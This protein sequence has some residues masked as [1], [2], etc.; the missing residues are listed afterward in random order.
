MTNTY[1]QYGNPEDYINSVAIFSGM[2]RCINSQNFKGG[3]VVNV[4]GSTDLDFSGADIAGTVVLDFLQAFGEIKVIVPPNWK[5]VN[6]A[7]ELLAQTHD[8]R[9]TAAQSL[10][11]DKV[12]M[13]KG[14]SLCAAVVIL[15]FV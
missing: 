8:K 7:S 2:K 13:L 6:D 1:Q 10:N 12:L 15:N 14:I 5:V 9:P 11:N 4:F 3:Q